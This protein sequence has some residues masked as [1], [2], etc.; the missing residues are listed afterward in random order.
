MVSVLLMLTAGTAAPAY[1]TFYSSAGVS[2]GYSMSFSYPGCCCGCCCGWYVG[3][4]SLDC[5]CG[6][7]DC[8][9]VVMAPLP[10]C[11]GCCCCPPPPCCGC[12]C[13]C[14][15]C[16]GCYSCCGC[17]CCGCFGPS[18]IIPGPAPI[19]VM[20]P[21]IVPEPEKEMPRVMPRVPEP[22]PE[23]SDAIPAQVVIKAPTDVRILVNGQ[24]AVRDAAVMTFTTPG[25]R[26][27]KSYSYQ[28]KAE[29][30]REGET[31]TETKEVMVQAGHEAV[32]D[33]THLKA[34]PV[35]QATATTALVT[36]NLPP[37]AKLY[38]DGGAYPLQANQRTFATPALAKGKDYFYE[39]KA[40]VV[41]DGK[42]HTETRKV[43]VEPGKH[44]KV[45]FKTLE[46]VETASR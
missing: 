6:F 22:T 36:V 5:C 29:M 14:A 8:R 2:A 20:P 24:M 17:C 30:V 34:P 42:T 4:Y 7:K 21:S 13:G 38:V 44:V 12:C 39:L 23:T 41:R 35:I 27:G 1:G 28:V 18:F 11:C 46:A 32:I 16:C 33:F 9:S 19:Q 26:K 43:A 37:D 15:K 3:P 10:T 45:D 31:V 25:L 40:E